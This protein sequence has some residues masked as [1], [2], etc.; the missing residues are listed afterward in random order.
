MSKLKIIAFAGILVTLLLV[1]RLF[2]GIYQ[3]DEYPESHFF[4][5][6]R[7][8]WKWY[9]YSPIGMSDLKYSDLTKEQQKEQDYF[10]EFISKSGMSR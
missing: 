5:K 2:C 3:H 7:P 10:D 6:H 4:I 1:M 9:F 8:V